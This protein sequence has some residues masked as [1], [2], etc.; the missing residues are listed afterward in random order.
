MFRAIKV[1]ENPA[2]KA[3]RGRVKQKVARV[4]N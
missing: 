2:W 1:G 3:F 4:T